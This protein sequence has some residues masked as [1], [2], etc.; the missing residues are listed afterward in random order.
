[1]EKKDEDLHILCPICGKSLVGDYDKGELICSSCGFVIEDRNEYRGPEWK[2]I[3]LEEKEKRVRVGAPQTFLLHDLGLTTEI[4][5]GT[6][7]SHGRSLS[8]YMRMSV[9]SMKKWQSRI[10]TISSEE[11]NLSIV[12]S[13]INEVSG[14][15]KL[16]K[17]VTETAAHTYRI[18]AKKRVA[19]SRSIIGMAGAATYLACRKFE[20][21]RSLKEIAKSIGVDKRTIAK[22]YRFMLKETEKEYIP[23]TSVGRYV[24]KL[25][26][27]IKIDP[28]VERLALNLMSETFCSKTFDGKAPAGLAAAFVYIS[29]VLLGE[30]APQREIAEAAEVTEVT[31]RNRSREILNNFLIRQ[32]L[33]ILPKGSNTKGSVMV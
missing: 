25:V 29:S 27:I 18:L 33:K 5:T 4:G 11:R 24:S 15:L 14:V 12:L 21:G 17:T 1:M 19:K 31:V 8:P 16:P 3:D 10:R 6:K 26:N 32:R 22:Y 23:P 30:R 20:T 7:D 28:K 9:K 13:K 2:A